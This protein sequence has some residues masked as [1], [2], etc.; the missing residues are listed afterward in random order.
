MN[1][2]AFI[3]YAERVINDLQPGELIEISGRRILYVG[4]DS[5]GGPGMPG[6]REPLFTTE[7][8]EKP[9]KFLYLRPKSMFPESA[10]KEDD[11]QT[12]FGGGVQI[13][14]ISSEEYR[15][16]GHADLEA[17]SKAVQELYKD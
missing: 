2:E 12:G 9:P 8:P 4:V 11:L 17:R 10:F 1:I 16:A 6:V 13:G 14:W 7:A 15:K 5:K 3:E